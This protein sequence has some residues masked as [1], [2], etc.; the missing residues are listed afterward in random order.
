MCVSGVRIR[1]ERCTGCTDL[2]TGRDPGDV[3]LN[4]HDVQYCRV[5]NRERDEERMRVRS[6]FVEEGW[7]R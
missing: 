7:R 3:D 5:P 4:H 2:F 1:S 6:Q